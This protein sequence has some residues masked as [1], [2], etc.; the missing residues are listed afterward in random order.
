ME[1]DQVFM[2]VSTNE[3]LFKTLCDG[4]VVKQ[5]LKLKILTKVARFLQRSKQQNTTKLPPTGNVLQQGV[6]YIVKGAWYSILLWQNCVTVILSNLILEIKFLQF[7]SQ[8]NFIVQSG[9]WLLQQF[10]TFLFDQN[11]RSQ[12]LQSELNACSDFM[13]CLRY[14]ILMHIK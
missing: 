5:F 1:G 12:F 14:Q 13:Q 8:M 6:H 7:H 2:Y 10:R 4:N 3:K 9:Y 11:L